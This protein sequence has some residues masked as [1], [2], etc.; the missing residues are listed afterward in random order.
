MLW[1]TQLS[2]SNDFIVSF[3]D[4]RCL[5]FGCLRPSRAYIMLIDCHDPAPNEFPKSLTRFGWH[6]SSTAGRSRRGHGVF[7]AIYSIN[8]YWSQSI[9]AGD[10]PVRVAIDWFNG[11]VTIRLDEISHSS[12][13]W[14]YVDF[15]RSYEASY[16]TDFCKWPFFSLLKASQFVMNLLNSVF[17]CLVACLNN[18][19]SPPL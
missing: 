1:F 13:S 7:S 3:T 5:S 2:V 6:K 4:I 14:S 19:E 10:L 17:V 8:F 11:E 16:P 9:L 15:S 18:Q 12:L